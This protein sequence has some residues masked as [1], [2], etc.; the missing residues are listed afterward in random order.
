M[1]N[2]SDKKKS[3]VYISLFFVCSRKGTRTVKEYDSI[4][5]SKK[6]TDV[7]NFLGVVNW[8]YNSSSSLRP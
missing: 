2:V 4:K 3:D 7:N 5:G 6:T 8:K 1:T